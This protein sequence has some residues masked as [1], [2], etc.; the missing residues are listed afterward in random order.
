MACLRL[1]T[2]LF[3][4]YMTDQINDDLELVKDEWRRGIGDK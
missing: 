2:E 1:A 3:G 4:V